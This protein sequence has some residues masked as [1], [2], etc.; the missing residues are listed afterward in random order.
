MALPQAI[1]RTPVAIG[2]VRVVLTDPIPA[3]ETPKSAE[4]RIEVVYSD[5]SVGVVS[6]NL[7]PHLSQAQINALMTFMNDMRTKATAEILP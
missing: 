7:A 1:T 5:G 2:G 4:Y 6:G 3:A